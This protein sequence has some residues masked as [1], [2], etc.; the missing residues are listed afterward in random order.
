MVSMGLKGFRKILAGR[1]FL[2]GFEMSPARPDGQGHGVSEGLDEAS[3]RLNGRS[4]GKRGTGAF[5]SGFEKL[6]TGTLSTNSVSMTHDRDQRI[7]LSLD[8]A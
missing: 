6:L 8:F 2:E 3:G 1:P 7:L 4:S 5:N